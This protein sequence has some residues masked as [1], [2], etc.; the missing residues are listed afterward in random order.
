MTDADLR[1]FFTSKLAPQREAVLPFI[2][3]GA[4]AAC[5]SYYEEVFE[6]EAI[7]SQPDMI[8]ALVAIWAGQGLDSL[9]ALE[10]DWRALASGLRIGDGAARGEKVS[11]FVYAMY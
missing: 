5:E 11:E 7:V 9:A 8:A 1:K 10:G 3:V 6:P 2:A 4:D